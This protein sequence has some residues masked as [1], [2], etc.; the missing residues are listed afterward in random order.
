MSAIEQTPANKAQLLE[1]IDR[2]WAALERTVN[3]LT[4]EQLTSPGPEGWSPKDHL[5]HLA[6]WQRVL[7][8]NRM[9]GNTFA[10]AAGMDPEA[11]RATANMT[12]E[13]GINDWFQR[14]DRELPLAQVLSN[15]RAA[16]DELRAAIA[17]AD[18]EELF[19][20]APVGSKTLVQAI[21]DDTYDHYRD[22]R[23]IIEELA[24]SR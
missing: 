18:D 10:E 12:A 16:H 1:W 19:R 3:R 20:P 4:E 8:L 23:R 11:A 7:L 22:H 15:Y 2:E 21:A 17:Q 6:A 5:T 14:R 24:G 9:Q 13:T